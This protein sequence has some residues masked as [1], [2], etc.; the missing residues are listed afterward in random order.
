MRIGCLGAARI[1]PSAMVHPSRVRPGA[2]LQSVA[3]RDFARAEE[4]AAAHGFARADKD[5]DALV[6]APDV[7]LVYNALPINLHAEW[8]IKALQAGKHVLCEKPFAMN[9]REVHQVQAAARASGKR[10][11]EAFHYRYHPSFLQMM[12]WLDAGEVGMVTGV[13]A[14]FNIAIDDRNG[15]EIRHL[16]ETGGGSFMDLGC[17]PLSWVLNVLRTRPAHIEA[18]AVLTPKGVDEHMTAVLTFPGAVKANLSSSMASGQGFAAS[19]HIKGTKGE[20][21]Y[22][23]PLAPH[24]RGIL[25]LKSGLKTLAPRVSRISTYTWQLDTVVHALENNLPVP[26]EGEAIVIQQEVLDAVYEAAGLKGL[27][28]R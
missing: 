28:Y 1:T 24:Y 7:D 13:D 9:V 8:T 6:G 3:A 11:I 14:K 15:T 2:V 22:V 26:T 16:P 21:E 19:L 20:I 23:N 27:R 25:T 5:Y 17:Y 10:V 18:K 12:A 4:F